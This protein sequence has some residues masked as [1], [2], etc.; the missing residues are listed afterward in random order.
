MVQVSVGSPGGIH[1]DS[2]IPQF[3]NNS[4]VGSSKK[5]QANTLSNKTHLSKMK[6]DDTENQVRSDEVINPV[7]KAGK[8]KF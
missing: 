5:N 4:S 1:Y 3:P 6:E 8:S 7:R 2:S